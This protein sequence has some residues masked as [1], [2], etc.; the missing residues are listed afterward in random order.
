MAGKVGTR[1]R[2]VEQPHDAF[3]Q[4]QIGVA[5]CFPE[6]PAAFLL[7]DH[8]Q[9]QLVHRRTAGPLENHRVKEVRA[10]LEHPHLTPEVA[11]QPRQGS[12]HRSLALA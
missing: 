3:D 4:D 7:T 12:G 1:R 10:A 9:V 6:Q 2:T 5:R 8:P 11:V